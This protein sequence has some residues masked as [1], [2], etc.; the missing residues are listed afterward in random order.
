DWILQPRAHRRTPFRRKQHTRCLH[1]GERTDEH[2]NYVQRTAV[3]SVQFLSELSARLRPSLFLWL[4]ALCTPV[5]LRSRS[6]ISLGLLV[7]VRNPLS[8]ISR[9]SPICAP[10]FVP[11]RRHALGSAARSRHYGPRYGKLNAKCSCNYQNRT[12]PLFAEFNLPK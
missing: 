9:L 5:V 6:A 1:I 12:R 3:A 10:A 4:L 7:A 2:H 11:S 8:L